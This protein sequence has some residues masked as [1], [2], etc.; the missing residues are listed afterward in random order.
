MRARIILQIAARFGTVLVLV[1]FAIT[2][3]VRL[4]PGDPVNILF[5]FATDEQRDLY[6][7]EL[8][9]ND[10]IFRYYI[11]WLFKFA[12]GDLGYYY[13]STGDGLGVPV[14]DMLGVALPRTLLLMIYVTVLSLLLSVP[15]GLYLAYR[16]ETRVDR[17]ISNVLFGLA[18]LPNFAVGLGLAF[19]LGVKL[20]WLP[21]LG[22][23]PIAEGVVE[24]L[25]S[26][27]MPTLS[28]AIGLVATFSRLL[29][30]DTIATLKEDFVTM[31]SSKG[32]SNAWILWRH[33]FRPSSSTL[34]TSAALNMA[35]LIGGAVIIETVFALNGFGMLL[36][37]SLATRQYLAIQ[38]LVALVAIAYMVFNLIVDLLYAVVDPRVASH[39][40]A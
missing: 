6:R 26:M 40:G 17:T 38:S 25:K 10:N 4:L 29:R 18:S 22:Y 8:G 28:L 7:T 36:T 32:L 19:L 27:I 16:A 12:S 39:R 9:L 37:V 11:E 2:V 30:V 21:V 5:P 1:T 14:T 31:A 3:L 35:S 34:L 23:V 15:L 24:H 13:S 20:N 33:V